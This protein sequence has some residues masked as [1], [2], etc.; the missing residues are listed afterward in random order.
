M[1]WSSCNLSKSMFAIGMEML[2]SRLEMNTL[3]PSSLQL[4]LSECTMS[5][6]STLWR[7]S[8]A[9]PDYIS[10]QSSERQ[11]DRVRNEVQTVIRSLDAT[12]PQF[13]SLQSPSTCELDLC[14][15]GQIRDAEVSEYRPV[16]LRNL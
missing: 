13:Q 12:A 16:S 9:I 2:A 15:R 11:V 4:L 1:L 6:L 14:S 8:S 3:T 7:S 10:P 5:F